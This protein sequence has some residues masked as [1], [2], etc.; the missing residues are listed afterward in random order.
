MS[1]VQLSIILG[2]LVV[3]LVVWGLFKIIFAT[4]FRAKAH[5]LRS[6][7]NAASNQKDNDDLPHADDR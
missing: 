7:F 4:Y 3:P 1:D 2:V 5:Y 6:Y